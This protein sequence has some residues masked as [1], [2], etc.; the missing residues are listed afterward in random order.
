[1]TKCVF[2]NMNGGG[3]YLVIILLVILFVLIVLFF[4][5][6]GLSFKNSVDKNKRIANPEK[7]KEQEKKSHTYFIISMVMLG[8]CFSGF[9]TFFK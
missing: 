2:K 6:L 8:L 1:M 4:T 5:F 3:K 7:Y 9:A